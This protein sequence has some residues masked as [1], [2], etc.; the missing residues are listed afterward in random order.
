MSN[1]I[2]IEL[3]GQEYTLRTSTDEAKVLAAAG[4]LR[5]KMEEY[6]AGTKSNIRLNVAIL[7]ALDIANEYLQLRDSHQNFQERVEVRSKK[8]IE[9]IEAEVE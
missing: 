7:A 2:K 1:L 8:I 6:Q 5:T 4:L 9:A 3:L